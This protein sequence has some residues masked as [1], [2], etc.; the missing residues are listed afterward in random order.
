MKNTFVIPQ[1]IQQ[2]LLERKNSMKD[3]VDDYR[4]LNMYAILRDDLQMRQELPGKM[5][6]QAGHAFVDSYEVA[7]L[8]R[9]EIISL[10]KGSGHGTKIA[11]LSPNLSQL[12]SAYEKCL[13]LKLPCALVIDRNTVHLPHFNGDPIITALGIG[14][15]Y[16]DE[17]SHITKKF[18]LLKKLVG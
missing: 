1:Y 16:K 18:Q 9:P 17:I 11:M 5:V 10:Y 14:P 15:V 2:M 6:S 4:P 7:K 3:F 13:N 12:I 8:N